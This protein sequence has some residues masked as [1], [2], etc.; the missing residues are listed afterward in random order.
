MIFLFRPK[1]NEN[2]VTDAPNLDQALINAFN[3]KA[4]TGLGAT[5]RRAFEGQVE[6]IEMPERCAVVYE[7]LELLYGI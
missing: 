6:I 5:E 4:A 3:M 2:Y 1:P 7:T